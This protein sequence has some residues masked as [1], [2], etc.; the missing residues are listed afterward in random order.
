MLFRRPIEGAPRRPA[1]RMAC[2]TM[3]SNPTPVP[4]VESCGDELRALL[5]PV[6]PET[7][8]HAYW[9]RKALFVKG[10]PDKYRGMFDRDAFIH[11]LAQGGPAA[12]DFL[13]ASF[14]KKEG[15]TSGQ[16]ASVAFN[17]S[18]DQA[19]PLFR[20][21]ATLCATQMEARV[22]TLAPFVAAIKR[23]LG[24]PGRAT[25]NAY[26]SPP[27]AGFNWHFD[28]RVASTMQIEGTKR[29][30]FSN[31]TAVAW[32][33]GNGAV[34]ADGSGTYVDGKGVSGAWEQIAPLDLNETTEV[35][36]E[37]GDLLVLPAGAWHEACGGEGGSL[38]LNLSFTPVSY[39]LLVRE[40]L[41][42]ALGTD[43]GWR[44]PSPLLARADG[45]PGEVDPRGLAAIAAQLARAARSLATLAADDT[46]MVEIWTSFVHATGLGHRGVLAPQAA[47]VEKHE[48]LRVRADG[49]VTARLADGGAKLCLFVGTSG[50]LDLTGNERVLVQRMLAARSFS[51]AE[52]EAWDGVARSWDQLAPILTQLVRAGLLERVTP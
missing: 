4:L 33:R 40:L 5:S 9:G 13:R 52:C 8:V 10:F 38:A 14:D 12:P 41:D 31:G 23:Q 21:G 48:R 46:A 11:A 7:F 49:D 34:R 20:A 47:P 44:G 36:L 24:Y 1:L 6:T 22:P 37:P 15:G 39:T 2:L 29:W 30:R 32:P 25:F 27:G 42:R 45:V 50:R 35:L 3:A 26:L 51:V 17:A 19:V 43:P 18:P 16:V 28:G